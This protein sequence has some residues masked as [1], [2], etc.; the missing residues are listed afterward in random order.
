MAPRLR[1]LGHEVFISSFYGL[2]GKPSAWNGFHV[3]PGSADG[4]GNDIIWDHARHV[5]ADIIMILVDAWVM[6]V[7]TDQGL[8]VVNV[9]PVDC[10]PLS[11]MDEERLK[12]SGAMAF[13][14]SRFGQNAMRDAGIEAHY[15]PHG[16]D[17]RVMA[18]AKNRLEI[19]DEIQMPPGS[20][21]IGMNAANKDAVRKGF[22]EQ[23]LAFAEFH[24]RHPDSLLM[25][26]ALTQGPGALTLRDIVNR[27]G[28]PGIGDAIR[29]TDQYSLMSGLVLPENIAAWYNA[30]D[31]LTSC[32]YGE[33][34]GIPIIEAQSCGTPV[35]ATAWSAM[36]E[37]VGSGWLVKGERFW[38]GAHR[39][40]WCKPSIAE[41]VKAYEKAWQA[42]ESG[43]MELRKKRA[44][45]FALQYDID[46]VVETLWAPALAAAEKRL[47]DGIA[48]DEDQVLPDEGDLEVETPELMES[49]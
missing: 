42:R 11:M 20:F 35:V 25:I 31:L 41:I 39:S 5:N 12:T 21:V 26:H 22:P 23:I 27:C 13:A 19:R 28:Y 46:T 24:E 37:L 49:L 38:N 33:G 1:D 14:I 29:F 44:R 6:A 2:H 43:A 7:P 3:L 36:I 48:A 32:S 10:S 15:T 17:T 9:V 30:I 16:I 47:T 18:P 4:Y 8:H 40:W 45:K 34:F